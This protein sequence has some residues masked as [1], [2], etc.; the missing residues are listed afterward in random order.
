MR[1]RLTRKPD[2]VL[3]QEEED[4]ITMLLASLI[5]THAGMMERGKVSESVIRE[6]MTAES[7]WDK[8]ASV[9]ASRDGNAHTV[10]SI[11]EER[12]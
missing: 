4:L 7:A 2:P 6:R 11:P 12:L 5:N 8:F 1:L 3:T 9:I 10:Y